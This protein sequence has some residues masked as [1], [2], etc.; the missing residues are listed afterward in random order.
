M[1]WERLYDW[2]FTF[3]Y[4]VNI[5]NAM[6]ILI[7]SS[8]IIYTGFYNKINKNRQMTKMEQ[9]L[10]WWNQNIQIYHISLNLSSLSHSQ[11]DANIITCIWRTSWSTR[12]LAVAFVQL[13]SV[14]WIWKSNHVKFTL[15]TDSFTF[16]SF[17]RFCFMWSVLL[18]L[19]LQHGLHRHVCTS[20]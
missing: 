6:E 8:S 16:V 2:Y 14:P 9:S 13:L 4:I 12:K 20:T 10:H 1:K 18:D 17:P 3:G 11:S 15:A 19:L 7:Y 5:T